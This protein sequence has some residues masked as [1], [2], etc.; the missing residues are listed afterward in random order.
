[1]SMEAEI[2]T[3]HTPWPDLAEAE[4]RSGHALE[5]DTEQRQA[6]W[7]TWGAGFAGMAISD[8]GTVADRAAESVTTRG[9]QCRLHVIL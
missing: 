1:M 6:G 7:E 8:L 3:T 2:V 9:Q 4:A 5:K